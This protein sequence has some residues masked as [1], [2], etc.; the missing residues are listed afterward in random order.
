MNDEQKTK[1][2]LIKELADLRQRVAVLEASVAEAEL[3]Q[4]ENNL[5]SLVAMQQQLLSPNWQDDLYASILEQLGQIAGADRVC[6]FE[7]DRDASGRLAMSPRAQ[8]RTPETE[9]RDMPGL[10]A[11][12]AVMITISAPAI[13]LKSLVP[14]TMAL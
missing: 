5:A 1:T 7:H 12:P 4:R 11:R 9:L 13:S 8:W 2:Q 3:I 14:V 6:I 10:R